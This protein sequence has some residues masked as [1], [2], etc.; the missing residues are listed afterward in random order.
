[1]FSSDLVASAANLR[2]KGG[3][4]EGMSPVFLYEYER[5]RQFFICEKIFLA[6]L[7]LLIRL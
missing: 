7:W 3:R 4:R 6:S 2:I 5:H 1:M